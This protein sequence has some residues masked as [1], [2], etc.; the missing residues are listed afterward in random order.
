MT[1]TAPLQQPVDPGPPLPGTA[2]ARSQLPIILRPQDAKSA[3]VTPPDFT[4]CPL[5]GQIG[6]LAN[7]LLLERAMLEA[8]RTQNRPWYDELVRG[9][10]QESRWLAAFLVHERVRG[11]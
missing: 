6:C 7:I 2:Y 1:A 10:D 9:H 5:R 8:S 3:A 4:G 11:A